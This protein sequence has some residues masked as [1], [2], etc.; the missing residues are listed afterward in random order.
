M[1]RIPGPFPGDD[2]ESAYHDIGPWI[3]TASS[4]CDSY[5]FDYANQALHVHWVNAPKGHFPFTTYLN[6][7]SSVYRRF[8]KSASK[9]RFVNRVLNGYPYRP[10]SVG[11]ADAPHNPSRSAVKSN[12]N[13]TPANYAMYNR[14]KGKSK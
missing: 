10:S 6:V 8:A 11:E 3:E 5:R 13:T 1:P 9:G 2:T 4:R 12:P 7:D 14:F